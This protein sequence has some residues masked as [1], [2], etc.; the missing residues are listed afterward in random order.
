RPKLLLLDEP[1]A[2]MNPT[3]TRA[4]M[5]LIRNIRARGVAVMLIEHDMQLVMGTSDRIAVL[6]YEGNIAEGD[7]ATVRSDPRVIAAYL[8]QEEL[9]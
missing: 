1:A 8:G 3:E 4:L 2:G 7:P 5:E 9:G 6:E